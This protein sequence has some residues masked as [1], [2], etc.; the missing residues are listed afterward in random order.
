V[1]LELQGKE[2]TGDLP[3]A[4]LAVQQEEVEVRVQSAQMEP[5]PELPQEEMVA[6]EPL[7]RLQALLFFM[8]AEAV[9]HLVQRKALGELEVAEMQL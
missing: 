4:L 8:A 6:R 7:L 9:D 5:I 2:T 1:D 3:R